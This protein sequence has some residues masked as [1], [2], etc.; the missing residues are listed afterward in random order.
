MAFGGQNQ[1]YQPN[2]QYNPQYQPNPQYNPQY[3]PNPQYNP[4]YQQNPQYNQQYQQNPQYNQ[5]YQQNP[6]YNQ[7]YQQNPQMGFQQNNWQ[8]QQ[9]Q[10]FQQ[11]Q[12][13]QQKLPYYQQLIQS[14]PNQLLQILQNQN[15]FMEAIQ[16][17]PILFSQIYQNNSM[18]FQNIR[19]L[20]PQQIN[21]LIATYPNNFPNSQMT[22]P[23]PPQP[24]TSNSNSN[25]IK[26]MIP[27]GLPNINTNEALDPNQ[28]IV[29]VTFKTS[30]GHQTN[31]AVNGNISIEQLIKK[32]IYKLSLPEN[33]I[34]KDIMFIF[35]GQQLDPKL[36]EDVNCT[37]G[38]GGLI[39]VYDVNNIIGA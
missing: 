39:S 29:N 14:N 5:Q 6:Q 24:N 36:K 32:Y 19:N 26:E 17:F 34:G 33:A 16:Y 3:Q 20:Y 12:Q 28:N 10:L 22:G 2:P 30:T 7:Q 13:Q 21:Q 18:L 27:R 38:N 15:N 37:L 31:M 25:E 35:N 4:Q 11:N 23:N 1:Q 9:A 8:Q